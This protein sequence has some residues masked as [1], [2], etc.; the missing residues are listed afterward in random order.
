MIVAIDGPS[1]A[2]KSS[3][4]R[5]AARRLGFHHI[6]TGAMYR[7]VTAAAL[8]DGVPVDDARA[9]EGVARSLEMTSDGRVMVNGGD[10]TDLLRRAEVTEHV[11]VVAAQPEVRGALVELQRAVARGRD[12][13]MEGRD[14][15]TIVFPDAEVKIFLTASLH[16]RARRRSAQLG[17]TAD[18]ATLD[19]I[20]RS[21]A[22]RDTTDATRSASP[23]ARARD[24]LEIDTSGMALEDVVALVIETVAAQ[25]GDGD[26]P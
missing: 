16:E 13:V 1:G 14:I 11:S 2:G 25:R 23:L 24:A 12:V 4:A 26:H 5:E 21:I 8:R 17:L 15:G 9:L 18:T 7:G 20:G 3:V 10:V 22:E 19:Q 6:D